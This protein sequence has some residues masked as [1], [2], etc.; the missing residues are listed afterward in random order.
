MV[1]SR[2]CSKG[3]DRDLLMSE[4]S[5][6]L[7]VS[8]GRDGRS[9]FGAA[10]ERVVKPLYSSCENWKRRRRKRRKRIKRKRGVGRG[11]RGK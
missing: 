8:C 1:G 11:G 2:G 9:K 7:A 5:M 3:R 10:V 4:H 6:H